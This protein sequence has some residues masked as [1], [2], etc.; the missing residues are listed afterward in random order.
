M[1]QDTALSILKL[2]HT[3]FLTGA[4]GAGK[5]YVLRAFVKYLKEHG[6]PYAVTAST[7]I[8]ATHING[9]TIHSWSGIGIKE[10]LTAYELEALEEKQPLYKKWTT[11]Q[12]LIIDEVS[13]LH[14][15]FLET[16]DSV[17]KHMR[18]NDEPFGGLQVVFTG[19]FFQLPPVTKNFNGEDDAVFAFQSRAW[20]AA[21]PVVCYLTEQYRQG[22]DGLSDVLN[23]IRDGEIT[24]SHYEILEGRVGKKGHD[25]YIKLYTHNENGALYLEMSD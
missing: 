7:G 20:V 23:A 19:D 3:A 1:T 6:V 17:A 25:D 14:A 16:L 21:K 15:T 13:M 2:G 8:A 24:E 4:A 12:V 18:R 10:R 5:S 9:T 11:T 22:N